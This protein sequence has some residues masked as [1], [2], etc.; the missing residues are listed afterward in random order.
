M[1]L[2][3]LS[4]DQEQKILSSIEQAIG[5]TNKGEAPNAALQKVAEENGFTPQV[6]RRMVEAYNTSKTLAHMKNASGEMRAQS[7]PLADASAI[8][9]GMYPDK[10]VAPA[11]K[12][13]AEH[14]PSFYAR[15]ET[16]NFLK[17]RA[18]K[19]TIPPMVE[20]AAEAYGPDPVV[21]G[22][23]L[24][25]KGLGLRKKAETASSEFRQEVWK[26]RGLV[27][28]AAAHFRQLYHEPFATVERNLV[29]EHGDM[30]RTLM[31]MVYKEAR[32]TEAR[33]PG[34]APVRRWLFDSKTEPYP[35]L[36]EALDAARRTGSLAK[37]AAQ[38]ELTYETFARENGLVL[39]PEPEEE[40]K[41]ARPLDDILNPHRQSFEENPLIPEEAP[42]PFEKGALLP[43]LPAA[44]ASAGV[45][46]VLGLK[47]PRSKGVL[48][49]AAE[50]AAD[51]FHEGKLKSI[52]TKA[53]INDFLSN[54]PIISS[55]DRD[56]VLGAFNQLSLLAPSVAQQPAVVRGMLR[57]MLQS[58]NV[59]EPHEAKQLVDVEQRLAAGTKAPATPREEEPAK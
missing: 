2:E 20:K 17:P 14:K 12:A 58:E 43:S 46:G 24:A 11:E 8:L 32:L 55:Y 5:L 13:A 10:P 53:M 57:R 39:P 4:K 21:V 18:E 47:E 35:H 23:K 1:P 44:A 36:T 29:G 28:E 59:V 15:A 30:A 22:R 27:K 16:R 52:H 34:D 45:M 6:V 42:R 37:G 56:D 25:D 7:F 41:E 48:E 51:P 50:E 31:D 26:V 40:V 19:V 49:E 38:A 54:D 9:A 33:H 3:K